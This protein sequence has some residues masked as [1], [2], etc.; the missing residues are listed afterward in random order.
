MPTIAEKI[1]ATCDACY[2]TNNDD[3]NKFLKAVAV[4]YFYDIGFGAKDAD[5]IVAFLDTA[6]NGWTSLNKDPQQA[7][8]NA[9]D[10]KFV[11]AGMTSA[12]LNDDHG[13][14]AVVVGQPGELSGAVIVPMCYAGSIGDSAV[15]DKRVSETF[16]ALAARN[17]R[18]RYYSKTPDKSPD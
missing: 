16:P 15:R 6:A 14:L 7:I 11:V 1:I 4:N 17:G 18:V 12:E 13:H 10:N 9:L 3:C 2:D 8:N 5:G